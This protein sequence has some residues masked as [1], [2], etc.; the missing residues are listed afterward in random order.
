MDLLFENNNQKS[1]WQEKQQSTT[2]NATAHKS[3]EREKSSPIAKT[4][5]QPNS[6]K[7]RSKAKK[8]KESEKP[9]PAKG[10]D[11][12]VKV[13]SKVPDDREDPKVPDAPDDRKSVASEVVIAADEEPFLDGEAL[14]EVF[15]EEP[16][17]DQQPMPPPVDPQ[18]LA[19]D[20]QP[21]PSPV[22]QRTIATMNLLQLMVMFHRTQLQIL[23]AMIPPP[24][25]P[26]WPP[27]QPEHQWPSIHPPFN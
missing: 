7:M 8:T 13:S 9:K 3:I 26:P 20:Q 25:W 11:Q 22:D 4:T 15:D 19:T 5:T 14:L 21:M 18:T 16:H 2:T 27:I 17:V 23:Q 10:K 6:P 24:Q 12:K 1:R